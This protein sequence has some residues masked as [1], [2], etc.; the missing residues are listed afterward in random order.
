M[1]EK[2]DWFVFFRRKTKEAR[3]LRTCELKSVVADQLRLRL[4]ALPKLKPDTEG[5]AL[6]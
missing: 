5:F 6:T 4:T 1:T 3:D 2:I